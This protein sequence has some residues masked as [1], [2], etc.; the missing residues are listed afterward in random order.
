[1]GLI[2]IFAVLVVVCVA[3]VIAT[4]N[5]FVV[6]RNKIDNA[7]AN[8]DTQIQR[9]F[10]LVPNLVET[11]KGYASFEKDVLENVVACRSGYA[12][13]SD[14][15]QKMEIDGKLGEGI[16]SIM[17]V[18][19]AYPELKANINFLEL[20]RELDETE[21]K[22]AYARQ[23]YN[24]AVTIYNTKLMKFPGNMVAN[25]FGLKAADLYARN[26]N[27]DSPKIKF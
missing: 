12:N 27:Q 2:V 3:Y 7:F 5:S 13:A 10:D 9:R 26:A 21:D 8:I 23:F 18:S 24:D 20:Q 16:K 15:R 17:A 19:E 22:L 11:V 25:M 6:S 4:Y 1:M 14:M